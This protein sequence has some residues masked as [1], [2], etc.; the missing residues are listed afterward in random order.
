MTT[1]VASRRCAHCERR[2]AESASALCA[3]C[4]GVRRIR[5]LYRPRT[6]DSRDATIRFARLT[7]A[8]L[9]E[10]ANQ[11]LPLFGDK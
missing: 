7:E 4:H 8:L 1:D 10:R 5:F 6:R 3:R 9:R 2:P 11:R